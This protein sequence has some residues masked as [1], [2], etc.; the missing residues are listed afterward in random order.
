MPGVA[1]TYAV[2]SVGRNVRRT[3]LSVVGIAVGVALAL[4]MESLNRGRE[5]LFSR[6]AAYSGSG[7][8]RVVPAGWRLRRDPRLRLS[9]AA[10]DLAA[11]RA[12][13]GVAVIA[14]RARAQV[15]LAMG[16]RVLPLEAVG[17]DPEAEPRAYRFVRNVVAGRWLRPDDEPGAAVVG[18]A[19]AD[20]LQAELGDE[21]LA[22]AVGK[23]GRIESGMLRI[24]GIVASGSEEIDAGTCRVTLAELERLTGLGGAGEVTVILE[25][26]HAT[27]AARAALAARVA[28]GDEV[29]TFEDLAPEFKGHLEQD[30]AT[31]RFVSA[32]ILLI[33]LL[34]VASAQLAAVLERR[35]EFAVLA[36]LGMTGGRMIRLV[37]LEALALGLMGAA[38]GLAL[39]TPVL[40]LFATRGLDFTR[41]MGSG[42]AFQGIILEPIIYGDLGAWIVPHVLAVALGATALASL[43]PAWFA[44]RT[45]PAA[46]LR[47][48]Q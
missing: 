30:S 42:Y 3:A 36:A 27:A 25:D 39:G 22:T 40:W 13:P 41:F 14:P 31:N 37:L 21:L 1:S 48:A 46:A 45:D 28:S 34:G 44:A 33:V 8:V 20:R 18:R 35:R 43:Y 6:A 4:F 7:H 38:L 12:L 2:R 24:V 9:D 32:V 10:A 5:E 26:H 47:V 29:L 23:G 19:V 16:T 17:V 11:A 15:L